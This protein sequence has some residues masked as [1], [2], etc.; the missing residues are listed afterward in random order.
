MESEVDRCSEREAW[1]SRGNPGEEEAETRGP[2]A[3]YPSAEDALREEKDS[4]PRRVSN[5]MRDFCLFVLI[6]RQSFAI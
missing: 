1:C 2:E 4:S 5:Q 6:L 3:S